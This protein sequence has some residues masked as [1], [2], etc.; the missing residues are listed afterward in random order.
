MQHLHSADYLVIGAFTVALLGLLSWVIIYAWSTRGDWRLTREGRH[1]MA[2]RTSL[3]AF[4]AMGIA[5]NVWQHYPGRDAIR[6]AIV[7]LFAASVVDGLRVLLLAQRER[8]R[9]RLVKLRAPT[10]VDSTR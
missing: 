3:S 10:Q 7:T 6:V 2:F 8:R 4:M 5:N 1:L 9:D